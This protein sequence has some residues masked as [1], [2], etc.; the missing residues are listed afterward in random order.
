MEED[1][2]ERNQEEAE[3]MSV[4][5]VRGREA[6]DEGKAGTSRCERSLDHSVLKLRL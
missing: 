2:G 3:G 5:S 4:N 6:D 1:K